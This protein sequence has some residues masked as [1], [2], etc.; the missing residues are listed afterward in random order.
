MGLFAEMPPMSCA[1]V[2]LS[3]PAYALRRRKWSFTREKKKKKK[4]HTSNQYN[5]ID[6]LSSDHFFRV[7]AHQI[8]QKHTGGAREALVNA[9]GR[10]VHG[11]APAQLHPT[12]HSFDELRYVCVAWVEAGIR[13]HNANDGSR[14]SIIAI[15]ESLD[16]CLSQEQGEMGVAVGCQALT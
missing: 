13:I 15:S 10:E 6:R 5:R 4:K 9:D 3:H 11:E 1:G 12:F 16:E 14:Q 2:V 7:H 8:P